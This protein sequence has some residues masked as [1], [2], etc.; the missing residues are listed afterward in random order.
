MPAFSD[1]DDCSAPRGPPPPGMSKS[2]V[3]MPRRRRTSGGRK[4]GDR[5]WKRKASQNCNRQQ[6]SATP[7]FGVS[8]V[9]ADDA[10]RQTSKRLR[11]VRCD[12]RISVC[13]IAGLEAFVVCSGVILDPI[14][15]YRLDRDLIVPRRTKQGF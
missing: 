14:F 8:P 3:G 2:C 6:N 13:I 11:L 12:R 1:P 15:L 5:S 9:G 4:D 10:F 7:G